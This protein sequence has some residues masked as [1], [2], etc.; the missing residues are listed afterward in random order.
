[1][2][3]S[4]IQNCEFEWDS[5]TRGRLLGSFMY[6]YIST[7]LV[8]GIISNNYGAKLPFMIAVYGNIVFHVLCPPAALIHTELFFACRFIQGMFVVKCVI[9]LSVN[10]AR[11]GSRTKMLKSIIFYFHRIGPYP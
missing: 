8:G 10:V 7:T 5:A 6:G 9:T 4:M 1:M 2:L 11:V 3:P